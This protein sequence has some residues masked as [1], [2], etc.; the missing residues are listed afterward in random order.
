ML[1]QIYHHQE[2]QDLSYNKLPGNHDIVYA[3]KHY[4]RLNHLITRIQLVLSKP[5]YLLLVPNLAESESVEALFWVPDIDLDLMR[6]LQIPVS[7][8]N[9]AEQIF[10]TDYKIAPHP[11]LQL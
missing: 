8:N 10:D 3:G 9:F 4:N 5:A 6:N 1:A 7:M 2:Y 11:V